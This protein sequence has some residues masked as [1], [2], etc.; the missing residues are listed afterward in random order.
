MSDVD[1][2]GDILRGIVG[3]DTI[4]D[5][6]AGGVAKDGGAIVSIAIG[7]SKACKDRGW[8]F[9]CVEDK[10]E[11]VLLRRSVAVDDCGG[12]DVGVVGVGASD[13]DFS[14]CEVDVVIAV[15]GVSA[16]CNGNYIAVNGGNDCILD[17]WVF[18]GNEQFSSENG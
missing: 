11:M 6:W 16:G 18:G 4:C 5:G 9:R 8:S 14:A 2:A 10:G 17:C 13:G 3:E 7:D 12:D 1:G 15:A